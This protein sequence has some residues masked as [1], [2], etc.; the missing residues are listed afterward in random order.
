MSDA[1]LAAVPVSA[2]AAAFEPAALRALFETQQARRWQVSHSTAAQR[3]EKLE[4]LRKAIVARSREIEDAL[5][6][7]F[8]KAA[9]ET[10]NTEVLTSLMELDHA[11]K[12]V[13]RWMRPRKVKGGVALAGTKSQLRYEPLGVVLVMAP[14]NYPFSLLINPLVAAMAA[15]NCVILKPSE[16]TP[17]TS[18]LLARLIGG[19]APRRADARS[20]S[21]STASC[22]IWV[23]G[24]LTVVSEGETYSASVTLSKP[25]TEMSSGTLIPASRSPRRT[26]AAIRSLTQTIAVGRRAAPPDRSISV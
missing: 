11:I 17:A 15:G 25:V 10:E 2:S 20:R 21:R 7:D 23:R 6:Q 8:R 12:H 16:K 5:R 18:A 14:W 13:A 24:M 22:P 3:R 4:A 19:P 9:A 1:R 26:P